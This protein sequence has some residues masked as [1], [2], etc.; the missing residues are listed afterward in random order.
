VKWDLLTIALAAYSSI[1]IPY[2]VSFEPASL[3]ITYIQVLNGLVSIVFTLNIFLNFRT[4]CISSVTGDEIFD[5]SQIALTY[6]R[7]GRFVLDLL[8]CLPLDLLYINEERRISL[9]SLVRVVKIFHLSQIIA[10][11][12]IRNDIKIVAKLTRLLFF[13]ALYVHCVACFWH[14]IV[15]NNDTWR[16]PA[17]GAETDFYDADTSLGKKYMFS[18]YHSIYFLRGVETN[19][20]NTDEVTFLVFILLVGSII[21][22][23][24]FGEIAV[25]LSN[26]NIKVMRFEEIIDSAQTTMKNMKLDEW[27]QLQVSDYLVSTQSVVAQQDEFTKFTKIISPSLQQ[28]VNE[29]IYKLLVPLSPLLQSHTKAV[30]P[31]IHL[32]KPRFLRPEAALTLQGEEGTEFFYLVRGSCQVSAWDELKVEHLIK[33]L[34][35]GQYFGELALIY[36]CMRTAT[37]RT[38][39]YT[40][41]AYLSSEDFNQLTSSYP[42]L[43]WTLKKAAT[44]YNDHWR[45]FIL[46]ALQRVPYL[47]HCSLRTLSDLMFSLTTK[48]LDKGQ[49]LFKENDLADTLY[50]IA[51]GKLRVMFDVQSQMHAK[52]FSAQAEL[53]DNEA[54]EVAVRTNRRKKRSQTH[55]PSTSIARSTRSGE[56]PLKL[57]SLGVGSVLCAT[58]ALVYSCLKLS[59][60][61]AEP[62]VV[63]CLSMDRLDFICKQNLKLMRTVMTFKE[64]LTEN[65]QSLARV[66]LI[67]VRKNFKLAEMVDDSANERGWKCMLRL[68]TS[69]LTLILR[70]RQMKVFSI[71]N[72]RGLVIK[73]RAIDQANERGYPA[74][75]HKIA[76]GHLD[77]ES[78]DS[79]GILNH[80][81]MSNPLLMQFA[82][83]AVMMR[84]VTEALERKV[85]TLLKEMQERQ[86]GITEVRSV[87]RGSRPLSAL[88]PQT[89]MYF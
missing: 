7:S 4:T 21:S 18:L 16:P 17:D 47:S 28:Q 73:L 72:I 55:L 69:V 32:L 49:V 75:A 85:S 8:I 19:P 60:V 27:L 3:G 20:S 13:L 39:T 2:Q 23:V 54:E 79:I 10:N 34:Q 45:L 56:V 76:A 6:L 62:T 42:E 77:A 82:A 26:L 35:V 58:Q 71:R 29:H 44:N 15:I 64:E 40:S 36:N 25:L 9:I 51:E 22:A 53:S 1:A 78:V 33:T 66:P 70:K 31:L 67:D 37:V 41:V 5:T 89:S 68:K 63:Y 24:M 87:L 80:D 74:L 83:K 57:E 84:Y 43:I 65:E 12:R 46:R 52:Q 88:Y 11:M 59:C 61:A 50:I 30:Q 48:H 38:V 81:E 14:L 86:A